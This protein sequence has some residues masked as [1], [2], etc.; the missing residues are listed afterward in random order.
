MDSRKVQPGFIFV[1]LKGATSDGH[2]FI[3]EAIQKGAVAVFGTENDIGCTVPYIRVENSRI[4]FANLCAMYFGYPAKNLTVIGVTGTDGKTT[5]CSLVY[6]ILRAAGIKTGMISTVN[7]IIGDELIDTGFHVTTPEA[8][9]IQRFLRLMVDKDITHVVL[10]TTSHALEQKR[11]QACEYDFGVLTN[12]THEH[13]D[14]HGSY[15]A[16]RN[17]KAILFENLSSTVGKPFGIQKGAVL[18]RD[19]PS[20]SYLSR[21]TKVN[22]VTYGFSPDA[23]FKPE[24]ILHASTGM[25]FRIFTH[26]VD[27]ENFLFPITTSLL[28][29]YNVMNILAACGLAIGQLNIKPSDAARGIQALKGIPGRMEKID[30]GQ[31]F[32][33]YVDFAHTPN[34]LLNTIKTGLNILSGSDQA[35]RVITVFGSAGLRDK[36]KRFLMAD[37]SAQWA[38]ITILT[39]EDPRIE[40]LED[41]LSEMEG[42]LKA[43]GVKKGV[44]YSVIPDRGE[45]IQYAIDIARAGDIILVCGKGHEQSM[46]FGDIEYLWDDRIAVTSAISQRLR[47]P[48]PTMPYLPT[49]NRMS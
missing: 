37:I 4:E 39:A 38:G 49:S 20:F 41:I 10:E 25:N 28:G 15:E 6:E 31:E 16:Y 34:A 48:G 19:D 43:N 47:I 29:E 30:L 40:S 22:T 42:A 46:C 26:F 1:A 32:L 44:G 7:A 17:A 11:V 18:N 12:I 27:R 33:C 5:T 2:R 14:F 8:D 36:R 13:L 24:S 45:A 23:D 9:D 21:V 3:H 35:G